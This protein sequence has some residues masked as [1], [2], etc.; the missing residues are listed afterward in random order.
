MRASTAPQN[1]NKWTHMP[2]EYINKGKGG[3]TFSQLYQNQN[4]YRAL[5]FIFS[6]KGFE[7]S[8][9]C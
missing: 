5:Y 4:R 3:H 8:S 2:M 7:F 1:K 9:P 6:R